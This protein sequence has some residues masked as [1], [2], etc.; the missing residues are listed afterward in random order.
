MH[1]WIY[2]Y[3]DINVVIIYYRVLKSQHVGDKCSKYTV[4]SLKNDYHL[5]DFE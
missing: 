5:D 2:R 3:V 1:V 4:T